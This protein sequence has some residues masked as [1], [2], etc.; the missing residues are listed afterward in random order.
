MVTSTSPWRILS[1]LHRLGHRVHFEPVVLHLGDLVPRE[2]GRVSDRLLKFR[3]ARAVSHH[4][5]PEA[6]AS[7][8]GNSALVRR[9]Q[10]TAGGGETLHFDQA[11]LARLPI[12]AGYIVAEVLLVDVLNF[13]SLGGL[14]F[15]DHPHGRHLGFG[16]RTQV[17]DI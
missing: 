9:E 12:E 17:P 7:I 14:V 15:H 6:I 11:Q 2:P 16:I 13:A 10:D 3:G 8:L 1:N 5:E 4:I